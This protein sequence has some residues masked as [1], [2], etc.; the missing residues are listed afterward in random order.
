MLTD[1]IGPGFIR[2][3]GAACGPIKRIW[4]LPNGVA[5]SH[6]LGACGKRIGVAAGGGAKSASPNT[7]TGG[8]KRLNLECDDACGGST[9]VALTSGW[10][11]PRGGKESTTTPG[12]G[13]ESAPGCGKQSAP[14][15]G[16]MIDDANFSSPTIRKGF[17]PRA[18]SVKLMDVRTNAS[19][20]SIS[21]NAGIP[22]KSALA[23]AS[24][25]EAWPA[26]PTVAR[27]PLLMWLRV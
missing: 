16:P 27:M 10:G 5:T 21:S 2:G 19:V 8:R 12:G 14:G 26:M 25:S 9:T 7:G 15:A 11:E 6:N 17:L 23:A 4:A 18:T 20:G 13:K 24:F 3:A 1:G 22:P